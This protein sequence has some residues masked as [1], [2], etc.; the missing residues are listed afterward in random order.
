MVMYSSGLIVKGTDGAWKV[1]EQYTNI[2]ADNVPAVAARRSYLDQILSEIK[3]PSLDPAYRGVLCWGYQIVNRDGPFYE[4][5]KYNCGTGY[6]PP[7][8][9][10]S[11]A[12]VL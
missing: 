4:Y 6:L 7:P 11:F 1:Y 12:T 5:V 9:R 8:E 3:S 10:L 2:T